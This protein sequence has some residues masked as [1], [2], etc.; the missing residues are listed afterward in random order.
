VLESEDIEYASPAGLAVQCY[1]DGKFDFQ[2]YERLWHEQTEKVV[3]AGINS[4]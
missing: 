2:A 3:Q 4:V 1:V